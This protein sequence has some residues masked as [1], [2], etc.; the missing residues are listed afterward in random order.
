MC[1]TGVPEA[2]DAVAVSSDDCVGPRGQNGLSD[3]I[4]H[5]HDSTSGSDFHPT[6]KNRAFCGANTTS[7]NFFGSVRLAAPQLSQS[8]STKP[9]G[10]QDPV[11][12]HEWSGSQIPDMAAYIEWLAIVGSLKWQHSAILTWRPNLRVLRAG[13]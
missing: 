11:P 4:R 12:M 9:E 3:C 10:T 8:F 1:R 6:S 2:D 13:E 5:V 7:D